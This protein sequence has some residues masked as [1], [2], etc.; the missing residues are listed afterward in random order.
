[1]FPISV[2]YGVLAI[3]VPGGIG[4]R[5]SILSGFL[6]ALKVDPKLAVTISALSRLWFISGE[7]FIFLL[8]SSI[9]YSLSR[10]EK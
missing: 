5:E 8:A 7:V 3:I 9:K 2:V 4:V 1:M 10:I 6:I